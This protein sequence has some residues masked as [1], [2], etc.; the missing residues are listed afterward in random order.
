MNE[1]SLSLPVQFATL[2]SSIAAVVSI[3]IA[4]RIYRRQMN[5]QLF[6]AFTERYENIMGSFPPEARRYR[7]DPV[8]EPPAASPELTLVVLRYLNLCSEEYYLRKTGHLDKD[9]WDIWE[10]EL[11]RTVSSSLVAREWKEL[12]TEFV[13]YPEFRD[14]VERS[15]RE[16]HEVKS[17]LQLG[18]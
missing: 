6:L 7:F 1:Q 15:Q 3:W 17:R 5:A 4:V 16:A 10:A 12:R 11:K 13:S 18:K 14:F 2:A 9:L 8:A